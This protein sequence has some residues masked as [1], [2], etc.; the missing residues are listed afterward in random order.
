MEPVHEKYAAVCVLC[1]CV[2]V[3]LTA[4]LSSVIEM[5]LFGVKVVNIVNFVT[6]CYFS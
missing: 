1:L 4:L 2:A 5:H 6:S 3:P